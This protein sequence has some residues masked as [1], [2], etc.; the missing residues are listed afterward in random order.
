MDGS[1]ICIATSETVDKSAFASTRGDLRTLWEGDPVAAETEVAE[2]YG[3]PGTG[4]S[5]AT[6]QAG[7]V[8]VVVEEEGP[9]GHVIQPENEN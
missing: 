8:S 1:V 7:V 9:A 6:E 3:E 4:V 2:E 5:A